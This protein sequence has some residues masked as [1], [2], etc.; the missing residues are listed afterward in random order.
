MSGHSFPL[1]NGKLSNLFHSPLKNWSQAVVLFN[2]HQGTHKSQL[3]K[4]INGL[5]T[6]TQDYMNKLMS[7]FNNVTQPIYVMLDINLK[8]RIQENHEKLS[9]ILSLDTTRSRSGLETH[10]Y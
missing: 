4:K 1:K 2:K 7:E 6:D 9:P 10:Y 5:H 3:E 8:L